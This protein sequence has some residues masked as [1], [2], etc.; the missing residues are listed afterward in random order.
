MSIF[1]YLILPEVSS[2]VGILL[3]SG[4]FLAQIA[5]DIYETPIPHFD[6]YNRKC[7]CLSGQQRQYRRIPSDPEASPVVSVRV[8]N[9]QSHSVCSKV[10]I[11]IENKVVKVFAFLLQLTGILDS[12]FSGVNYRTINHYGQ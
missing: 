5:M 11:I 3:L 7:S 10:G 1:V 8:L 12:V 2:G 9:Y 6:S 4:V